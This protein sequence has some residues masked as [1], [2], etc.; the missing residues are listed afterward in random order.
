MLRKIL[1]ALL[2][3]AL[4]ALF[5][6]S[7]PAQERFTIDDFVTLPMVGNGKLSPD[8][9]KIAWHRITRDLKKNTYLR[10]IWL[11][12]LK[13]GETRQLT[14]EPGQ[15][16][17]P[18]WAP[19]GKGLVFF[20]TRGGKLGLFLSR[21][22]GTDPEQLMKSPVSHPIFS[23][24]GRK[25][26]FLAAPKKDPKRP[27]FGK[28]P[29]VWTAIEDVT[30][31]PQLWVY[32]RKTKKRK[33]LSDGTTYVYDFDWHPDGTRLAYTFDPKGS[34]G[35]SED[36][37]LGVID[38]DGKSETIA[39]GPVKYTA[40]RWSPD[41]SRLA[42]WRDRA[43]PLDVYLT[44]NDLWVADPDKQTAP[45]NLTSDFPGSPSGRFSSGADEPPRWSPDGKWIWFVGAERSN[46][47]IYRVASAGS[48]KVEAVT[49]VKG[50][51]SR[52][53]FDRAFRYVAFSWTD[54]T[55]PADL[56]VTE[57]KPQ[58]NGSF[59]PRQITHARKLVEK[60]GLKMPERLTWK[61]PDGTEVEGFLFLPR[62]ATDGKPAP[63]M[64][65]AHGGPA[66]RWGNAFSYRYMWHVFADHGIGS[67]IF[68]P[69]G[70]TAYGEKFLRGN[71]MGFGQ[72]DFQDLMAAV[73]LLIKRGVT[74]PD[75]IGMTGYSYGG[76]MTN[77]VV[78]HTER[79]KAAVSIAGGFNFASGMGQSNSILPRAYYQ[80]MESE[81]NMR[82]ML[83][84]SPVMRAMKVKTPTLI[85]HGKADT[86]VHHMQAVEMFT[87]LQLAGCPSKLVLYPGEGHGINTPKHMRHYL[88]TSVR[89]I[90]KYL[91]GWKD[92]GGAELEEQKS[93]AKKGGKKTD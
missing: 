70:S 3:A 33:Q 65:D 24:D 42:Y 72:G 93:G 37:H 89:W 41:G 38:L 16:W 31:W 43:E 29:E 28:D 18:M 49:N 64:F 85:L 32:D 62:G 25:I 68:N 58:T 11:A 78:S 19:R 54:F 73:D 36:H 71:F 52:L 23:P 10:Q 39:N 76:F 74:A 13:S 67:L 8:G 77:M 47:N 7:A 40:P 9:Q 44:V 80:P 92:A 69:R 90:Q 48:G 61:S 82:R 57:T 87:S 51:I 6:L 53:S 66:F 35:L 12:D 22:D 88:E 15:S 27:G 60:Y 63:V 34:E 81:E 5:A 4:I 45:T 2:V 86:A 20:S 56:F 79:F 50:E 1:P 59:A 26:A 83:E 84:H 75:R 21:L 91:A 46:L 30:K 55:S 14:R 17:G